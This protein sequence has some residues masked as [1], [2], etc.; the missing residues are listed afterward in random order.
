MN[1]IQLDEINV[2]LVGSERLSAPND[3]CVYLVSDFNSS[4]LVDAGAGS[5]ESIKAIINNIKAIV[6][7]AQVEYILVTHAHIDHVGG[8]KYIRGYLPQA[9]IIAHAYA[10]K[11]IENED[12]TLSAAKWYRTKLHSVYIDI[13]IT[14]PYSINL[15]GG[16]FDIIMTPGHTPGSVVGFLTTPKEYVLFGQDIHG[17]FMSEFKSDIGQ[18]RQS[19]KK[20]LD[21]QPDYLCEGHFGIIK[22]KKNVKQFIKRYL[23]ES[24]GI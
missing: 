20:I 4:I 23:E 1:S 14:Q 13:K 9:E 18:W 5:K 2:H 7:L 15:I 22:G 24:R 12:A 21:L 8:L 16:V 3:C 17:P 6:N 10:A 11:V 19:M